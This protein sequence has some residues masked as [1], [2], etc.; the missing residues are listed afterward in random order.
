M[1]FN[2]LRKLNKNQG[3]FTLLELALAMAIG[4]IIASAITM[5]MFQIFD[6]SSRTSN[7]MTVV[8]Q[9]Q[10][11]GYWVS[12]DVQ[13]AQGIAPEPLPDT[14][15]LPLVLNWTKWDGTAHKV[16]YELQGTDFVRR[17]HS[18]GHPDED[19]TIAQF[20]SSVE[21]GPRPYTGGKITFTV[22]ATLGAGS[23][24]QTETRIYEVTPRPGSS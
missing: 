12:N 9:V 6:S 20:V 1:I 4:G 2:R 19:M 14:D 22:T 8:R 18:T 7:H 15:G 21:V 11:A 3:G 16:T 13:M 5:T 17:Y 23:S 24:A 10:S